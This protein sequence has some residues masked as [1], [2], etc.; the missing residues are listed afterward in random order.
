MPKE[1]D[2]II[3]G[4]G[5]AG[6][7]L[8][9]RMLI[10]PN[11]ANKQILVID[12]IANKTN[13]RTWCFWEKEPDVFEPI[14]HHF[15]NNLTFKTSHF[16]KKYDITP[17]TYKMILGIDFYNYVLNFAK[18]NSNITFVFDEVIDCYSSNNKAIVTTTQDSFTAQYLF[19]SIVPKTLVLN[20]LLQHFAGIFIETNNPVFDAQQATFMDFSVSQQHGTTF[21]YVLPIA[22]NKALVEYTLFTKNVLPKAEYATQIEDYIINTLGIKNFTTTHNEFG[23]I[24][25][26]YH[27]FLVCNNNIINIGANGGCIKASTG[28]AFKNIQKQ[29]TTIVDN[30]K[31]GKTLQANMFTHTTP[32]F[33]LYDRVLLNVLEN[34]KMEGALVFEQIFKNNS[35]ANVLDFLG[36]ESTILQDIKIMSSVPTTVFLPAAIKELWQ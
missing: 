15:W 29:S 8:L 20:G 19:N 3:A 27:N 1:Y 6:L 36:N 31:Q 28:F 25:M 11:L 7:S 17:Y 30:L 12:K 2:Y 4:A 22:P 35:I 21:M 10:D 34:K 5:C 18:K 26:T 33:R 24:P 23:V 13:D 9:Y 16:N 32:K 14:V